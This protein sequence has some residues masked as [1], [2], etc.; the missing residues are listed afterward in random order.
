MLDGPILSRH[1]LPYLVYQASK[2]STMQ[3]IGFLQVRPAV[4]SCPREVSEVPGHRRPHKPARWR[5]QVVGLGVDERRHSL[6]RE[7]SQPKE[8]MLQRT[9]LHYEH[10]QKPRET[11]RISPNRRLPRSAYAFFKAAVFHRGSWK[12]FDKSFW[13][14]DCS[15][16]HDA[17]RQRPINT[18]FFLRAK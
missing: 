9:L 11:R 15:L 2:T 1:G 13:V 17:M 16:F 7:D 5:R 3:A 10:P 14:E 12:L 6:H 4:E 18:F 8:R